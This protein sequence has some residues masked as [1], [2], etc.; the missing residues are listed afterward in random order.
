[1]L[2]ISRGLATTVGYLKS[3]F[4]QALCTTIRDAKMLRAKQPCRQLN[5]QAIKGNAFCLMGHVVSAICSFVN[6]KCECDVK[7]R[8]LK[9]SWDK[10]CATRDACGKAIF[11][12]YRPNLT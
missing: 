10:I 9:K 1:M 12:W 6:A 11:G 8:D 3:H 4:S 2:F 7:E 5:S